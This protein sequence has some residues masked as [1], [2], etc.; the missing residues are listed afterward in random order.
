M[1]L[2]RG[3]RA[4][5]GF[6]HPQKGN[7]KA[8]ATPGAPFLLLYLSWFGNKTA[9]A[10]TMAQFLLHGQPLVKAVNFP[11]DAASWVTRQACT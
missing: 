10:R 6:K 2:R 5:A 9:A 4:V 8:A 11:I 3:S 7:I 1:R